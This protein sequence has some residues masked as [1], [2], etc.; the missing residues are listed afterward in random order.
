MHA[1]KVCTCKLKKHLFL[2][3]HVSFVQYS[4]NAYDIRC[5]ARTH[6]AYEV[7]DASFLHILKDVVTAMHITE[8]LHT[9]RKVHYSIVLSQ[10]CAFH[11]IL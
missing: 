11:I 9:D 6:T 2:F 8:R 5:I 4:L 1:Q 3:V 10:C 7:N